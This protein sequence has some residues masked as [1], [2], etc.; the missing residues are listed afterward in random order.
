MASAFTQHYFSYQSENFHFIFEGSFVLKEIFISS[1]IPMCN[2]YAHS[3]T[4][5]RN[6]FS[7]FAECVCGAG[8][9]AFWI[10][11]TKVSR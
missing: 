9:K 10:G 3:I 1:T 8:T 2:E 11:R 7:G 4:L 6:L 5:K